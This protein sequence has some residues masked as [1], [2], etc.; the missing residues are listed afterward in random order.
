M[1]ATSS[2]STDVALETHLFWFR[3]KKEIAA[4][5]ILGLLAGI[6]FAGYRFYSEYRDAS[7]ASLLAE[8]K[9]ISDYQQVIERY[10]KTPASADAYLLQA[11]AQRAEK[12]FAEANA[13]LQA[14]I[15]KNPQHELITTARMAVA[16]NLES[17]GRNDEALAMYQQVATSYPKSFNAPLALI[18]RTHL[19]KARNRTEEARQMCEVILTQYRDSFWAREAA[20]ELRSLQP[21]MAITPER[22][23]VAPPAN[24]PPALLARPPAAQQPTAQPKAAPTAKPK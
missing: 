24:Q 4:A 11:D 14:F 3:F 19:L 7:A 20:Q 10:P 6:G 21:S 2:P 23:P 12:K 13:T 1:P 5:L 18:S 15:N 22:K 8:A 16:A 17:M 9:G